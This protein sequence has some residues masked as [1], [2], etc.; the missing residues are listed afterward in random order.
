MGFE[1]SLTVPALENFGFAILTEAVNEI[2]I[3]GIQSKSGLDLQ[4]SDGNAAP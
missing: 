3:S 2:W 1:K 4:R